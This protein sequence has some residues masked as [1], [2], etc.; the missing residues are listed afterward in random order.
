MRGFAFPICHWHARIGAMKAK[1]VF[2]SLCVAG[3]VIPYAAFL[4]WVAA[5]GLNLRLLLQEMLA[6]RISIF[7]A[8]DVVMSAVA[9]VA[10]AWVEQGR[11][12]LRFRWALLPALLL[13]GVSLAL[14]LLLYLRESAL[15]ESQTQMLA[16]GAR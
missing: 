6:N 3:T 13:V 7:F 9:V 14:P 8:L 4:P 11:V 12:K 2:L 16:S 10:F 5:H 1:H 15:D